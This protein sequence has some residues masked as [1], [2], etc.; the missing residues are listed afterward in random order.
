LREVFGEALD[1][2]GAFLGVVG[3]ELGERE[4]G[5]AGVCEQ[6]VQGLDDGRVGEA[7]VA[8]GVLRQRGVGEVDQVDVEVDEDPLGVPAECSECLSAAAFG[9]AWTSSQGTVVRLRRSIASRSRG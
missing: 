7:L 8:A 3:V 2:A 5:D 4:A 1:A 6:G 9:S